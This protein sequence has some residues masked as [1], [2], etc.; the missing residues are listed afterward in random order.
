MLIEHVAHR[1]GKDKIY[2]SFQ[3]DKS[4][5]YRAISYDAAAPA[6]SI[7]PL[8][9][10]RAALFRTQP[11]L[12]PR[13][14]LGRYA[15]KPLKR[16]VHTA[17]RNL[18]ALVG[19]HRHFE[20]RHSTLDAWRASKK[21]PKSQNL[22][23]SRKEPFTDFSKIAKSGDCIILADAAGSAPSSALKKA[24]AQGIFCYLL[25]HD[26]IQINAPEFI[27]G[28]TQSL[29]F[30]NW[31]LETTKYADR[32]L[33]NSQA[34]AHDLRIFLE[35]YGKTQTIDV[36]PL[37]VAGLPISTPEVQRSQTT[38]V[39]TETYP[40]LTKNVLIDDKIRSLLKRPYVLCVGTMETR[41]NMW[42]LAQAWDRLRQK[43]DIELPRL[44]FVGNPG[45]LNQD[46]ERW[47]AASG[48][49]HGWV[50]L[51]TSPSDEELD[52]LYRNCLFTAM[53]SFVEGWGL[54]VGESL[55]YGKTAVVSNAGSL[56]EVGGDLV[57]YFDPNSISSITSTIY[58]MLVE[59]GLRKKLE[60]KIAHSTLRSWDDVAR[61]VLT[62]VQRPA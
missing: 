13:P 27:S 47:M 15:Q 25:I 62:A 35:T 18:N 49:L 46:F 14:T 34:T 33:A 8:E 43:D 40:E 37:A 60:L 38:T 54:P 16:S 5:A 30:H 3:D 53:P 2:I 39:D 36:V 12:R 48:N 58:R 51:I 52:F 50:E 9:T 31:L 55:S 11:G 59:E 28:S 44:V 23:N 10:L 19:N 7:L 26:L 22:S 56:P 41:K 6:G 4:N 32:Y 20:K 57:L 42:G 17:I 45:W 61:D 1:I 21:A 29:R 24:Q